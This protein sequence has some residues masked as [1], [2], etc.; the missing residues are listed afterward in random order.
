MIAPDVMSFFA[1]AEG[2]RVSDF[3]KKAVVER[4]SEYGNESAGGVSEGTTREN[5]CLWEG[6]YRLDVLN[7]RH[8]RDYLCFARSKK[9]GEH[10]GGTGRVA[11]S[12]FFDKVS[13]EAIRCCV[14]QRSYDNYGWRR[15]ARGMLAT[16]SIR[17]KQSERWRVRY[18]VMAK[19]PRWWF[20]SGR[21][22]TSSSMV[23][24][25]GP[26]HVS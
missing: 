20:A 1:V 15:S 22:C 16:D 11:C 14:G 5:D 13:R 2:H 26:R 3:A 7:G 25:A 24:N 10:A 12:L 18:R 21:A 8:C 23:S 4:S 17:R 19:S 9:K 6:R